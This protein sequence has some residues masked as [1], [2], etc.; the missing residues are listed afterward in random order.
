MTLRL[1]N[2]IRIAL[3]TVCLLMV[4]LAAT[5]LSN[6]EGWDAFDFAVAGT[7]IFGTGL[8]YELV[9]SQWSGLTYKLAVGL[10]LAAGFLTIWTNLAVGIIGDGAN[11]TNLLFGGVLMSVFLGSIIARLRPLGMARTMFT[12]AALQFLVPVL[13]LLIWKFD[14]TPDVWKGAVG[15]M[16]FVT[17]WVGSGLLFRQAAGQRRASETE[18]SGAV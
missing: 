4:P 13:G 1:K 17:L 3:V 18:T 14:I 7:L 2:I 10:A 11:P 16:L 15:N 6:G 12:A 9:S 8:M 5:L